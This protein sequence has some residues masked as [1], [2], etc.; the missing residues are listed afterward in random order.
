MNEFV[1]IQQLGADNLQ[2]ALNLNLKIAT[3]SRTH[4]KKV[5]FS[6]IYTL[7]QNVSESSKSNH[8]I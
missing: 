8:V 2:I 3:L 5:N 7:I 4:T 1:L 6:T